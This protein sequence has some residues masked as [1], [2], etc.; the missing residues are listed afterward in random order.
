MILL[1]HIIIALSSIIYTCYVLINP[2]SRGLRGSYVLVALTL[3]S[4]T[5]LVV[6]N[7]THLV[8][9]CMTGIIY[10]AVMIFGIALAQ[11]RLA[12]QE[13]KD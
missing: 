1:T 10:V 4:G 13:T 8:R 5:V 11:Y 6:A 9:A 3:T 2:S 7:S 12:A